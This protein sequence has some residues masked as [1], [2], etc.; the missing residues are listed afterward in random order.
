MNLPNDPSATTTI[1]GIAAARSIRTWPRWNA[2][3]IAGLAGSV[4]PRYGDDDATRFL[5][6]G[7]RPRW[8]IALAAMAVVALVATG[9]VGWYQHRLTW[10]DARAWQVVSLD[11]TLRVDGRSDVHGRRVGAGRA[12]RNRRC[13]LAPARGAHRR[14]GGWRGLAFPPGRDPQRAASHGVAAG[15]AVGARGRRRCVRRVHA[16]RRRARP[17]LRI[18]GAC[19]GRRQWF[20]HRAQWL[21]AGGQPL[22]RSAGA[23]GRARGLR[24]GGRPGTPYDLG[25]SD[26]FLAALRTLDAQGRDADPAGD[27]VRA[28]VAAS[29]PQ[30]AISLVS[31]LHAIPAW[32]KGRF[33]PVAAADAGRCTGHARACAN[34]ACAVA[35]VERA[36]YPRFKRWWTQWPDAFASREDDATLLRDDPR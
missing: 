9:G 26:A 13:D 1:C 10:P 14:S 29:R 17:R 33:R 24:S 4:A 30:D 32:A 34:G 6:Q 22:A 11:G 21:G 25:A 12:A 35:V 15:H 8:R 27:A 19:R 3:G 16:G 18:R 5:R 28:L 2:A 7:R 23:A 31:L 36:P 20:A